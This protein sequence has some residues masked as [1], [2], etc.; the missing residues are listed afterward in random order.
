MIQ[1]R[2]YQDNLPL[3]LIRLNFTALAHPLNLGYMKNKKHLFI[4]T[5]VVQGSSIA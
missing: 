3:F 5:W 2:K 4:E 1:T